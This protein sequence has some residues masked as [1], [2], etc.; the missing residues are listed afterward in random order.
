[1][2]SGE[3]DQV[4]DLNETDEGLIESDSDCELQDPNIS[5]IVL[6]DTIE[7]KT[8]EISEDSD[9][10]VTEELF[11]IT[12][13]NKDKFELLKDYI[14][15]A[16]RTC[17]NERSIKINLL[18]DKATFCISVIDTNKTEDESNLIF[19]IDTA[20][21]TRLETS[22]VPSYRRSVQAVL[23]DEKKENTDDDCAK[24]PKM[25]SV[26]F[27]CS[28]SHSL[29]DCPE[30]RN[31]QRINKARK[32]FM[33]KT[34]RYHV[35][36][37]QRFAH[38]RPGQMSNELRRALGLQNRELPQFIYKMRV[39]GYPPGWLEDA[40]VA[41]SGITLFDS[42]GR[43]VLGSDDE[44]G[45]LEENKHKYDVRKIISYPGFN[46]VPSGDY[47]ED[48]KMPPMLHQDQIEEFIKS[49][50]GNIVKGY[51]RK[52]MKSLT[53]TEYDISQT[54]SSA[55]MEIE[56]QEDEILHPAP[57]I[58][59]LPPPL[60]PDIRPPSP[61]E[62]NRDD[63]IT[64]KSPTL[65]D[66]EEK[67]K[68]I[69]EALGDTTAEDSLI[70]EILEVQKLAEA[71][72]NGTTPSHEN[73]LSNPDS[74][75]NN[76]TPQQRKMKKRLMLGTPLLKFSPYDKLPTGEQFSK[77]VSDV[78]NFENLPDSTGKYEQMKMVIQNVR[79]AVIKLN[80]EN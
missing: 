19:S 42:E 60:P 35:D 2:A 70:D 34:E 22:S 36:I 50:R 78:I 54:N 43:Q 62:E 32:Q 3:S 10:L 51:K 24:R 47:Y 30:P 11:K 33:A 64:R 76:Q 23:N 20:P 5:V 1:M 68:K 72:N 65:E 27:N 77:G 79:K 80:E 8:P 63:S 59:P 71:E 6:D 28:G 66:L 45:E 13:N 73:S 61:A 7:E 58:I 4:N 57:I 26:C 44:E 16:V 53:A 9:K 74:E 37:E 21:A 38:L 55:D 75:S 17:L 39:L 18:E 49:L 69:M 40:K 15:D 48:H 67:Q 31:H 12:F 41:N 56:N 29:K 25:S 14:K 46:V 52:K